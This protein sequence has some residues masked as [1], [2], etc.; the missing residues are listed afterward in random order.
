MTQPLLRPGQPHRRVSK[1]DEV[2]GVVVGL[3]HPLE[4][5][6]ALA[7]PYW[8]FAGHEE[9]AEIDGELRVALIDELHGGAD[10]VAIQEALDR[11]VE[12]LDLGILGDAE[13][14]RPGT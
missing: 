8:V 3:P 9:S 7:W 10:R 6:A 2:P 1:D 12:H 14:E 5:A 4:V 13:G 11:A